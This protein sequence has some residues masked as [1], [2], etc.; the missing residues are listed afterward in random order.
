MKSL[1]TTLPLTIAIGGAVAALSLVLPFEAASKT[2]WLIGALIAAFTGAIV[3]ALKLM[4]AGPASIKG[5]AAMKAVLT[6]QMLSLFVRIIA[7]G[8][9]A[10]ALK[11]AEL[12]PIMFVFSFALV[13]MGQQFVEAKSLLARKTE[14]TS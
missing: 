5:T 4:L 14:V 13:S 1:T 7:V 3:L 6:A 11:N 12:S 8:V 9:G 2:S 10:F